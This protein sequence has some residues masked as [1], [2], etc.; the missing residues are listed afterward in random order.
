M[1]DKN[2][3]TL[4]PRHI[5]LSDVRIN[6]GSLFYVDR[7]CAGR[8]DRIVSPEQVEL[9]GRAILAEVPDLPEEWFV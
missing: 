2:K 8:L 3:P 1:G 5:L 9:V 4:Q 7:S 6:G